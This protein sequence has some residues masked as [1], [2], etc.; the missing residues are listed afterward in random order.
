MAMKRRNILI[1]MADQLTPFAL[2]CYGNDV[3]K[4]PHIDRL[5]AE[6]AVF[7]AAYCNSPLC[8]P[9]RYAFMTGRRISR[10]GGWD[11]AAHLPAT[12]PTF[13]HY[14]RHMGY[15]T[16]LSGK[17]HFVGPDQLHGI[18][19]RLT[20]DIYPGDFGWT[21]DWTRPEH[22]LDRWYHNMDNVLNAGTGAVTTQ[23]DFD[24]ETGYCALR[25]LR[26]M[27]RDDDPR[28]FCMMVSFTHPHDPYVTRP[29]Y[30]NLYEGARI[31]M[32]RTPL[33]APEATDPHSLRLRHVCAMD[34]VTITDAH[35]RR[36]RRAYYGNVSYVDDW[37]GSL[38]GALQECGLADDTVTI[39][40]SDHGDMLGERGMWYK[41][42]FFENSVRIPL[43]I[44]APGRVDAGRHGAPVSAVDLAPTLMEL[45]AEGMGEAAP[46]PLLPLDGHRLSEVLD[47]TGTERAGSIMSEYCAEG[48]PEPMVMLRQGKLKYIHCP[49]DPD[50]LYDLENDPEERRN[51]C[52]SPTHAGNL[53][54]FREELA[55]G[56]DLPEMKQR[57]LESQR[58]RFFLDRA[59]RQGRRHAWDYQPPGADAGDQYVRNHMDLNDVDRRGRW[60]RR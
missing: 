23:L 16:A 31:D 45:A 53:A 38:T 9:A 21:P 42:S 3:V 52:D 22:R 39:L 12:E 59:L 41:M 49:V 15:R 47:G 44:H 26:A 8:A 43:I 37:V 6:G 2:G 10:Y 51:L 54:A 19:E 40:L 18:E 58:L 20:T 33:L 14:L 25:H 30:W 56:W 34:G 48:T 60:P 29:H 35:V 11:N 4:T 24:D 28:P 32:P 46:D 1:I 27:A 17:M 13:I 5:G 36:A 55:Q 50:Q 57:I 7:D